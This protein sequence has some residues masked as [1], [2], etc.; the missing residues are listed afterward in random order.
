[1]A[2]HGNAHVGRKSAWQMDVACHSEPRTSQQ[3]GRRSA[4]RLDAIDSRN[5]VTS[6]RETRSCRRRTRTPQE[7]GIGD[8]RAQKLERRIN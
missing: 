8:S 7:A 5:Q 3:E 2:I 4:D 1:M 6:I